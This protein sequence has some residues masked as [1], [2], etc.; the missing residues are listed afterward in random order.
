[1]TTLPQPVEPGSSPGHEREPLRWT[2]WYTFIRLILSTVFLA[3]AWMKLRDPTGTLIAVY[4]YQ[5]LSW[6]NSEWLAIALPWFEGVTAVG[7]WFRRTRL[8]AHGLLCGLLGMFLIAL[9]AAFIR[10][11]DISCGC[12][13]SLDANKNAAVR[14][15]QDVVLLGFCLPLFRRDA[16]L[17]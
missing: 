2:A 13:G 9:G 15:A 17:R 7:L 14:L 4:Q 16:R 8:G 3:A 11:L 5:I 10:R 12:F 6:E 1:M